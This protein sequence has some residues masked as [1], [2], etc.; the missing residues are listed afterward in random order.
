MEAERILSHINSSQRSDRRLGNDR[1]W[2]NCDWEQSICWHLWVMR[3]HNHC[4]KGQ[5]F[6][7]I[8]FHKWME[9]YFEVLFKLPKIWTT[10]RIR[11]LVVQ[12]YGGPSKYFFLSLP[13]LGVDGKPNGHL[14]ACH[15]QESLKHWQEGEERL[16]SSK[17]PAHFFPSFF[18]WCWYINPIRQGWPGRRGGQGRSKYGPEWASPIYI[19]GFGAF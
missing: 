10:N 2:V 3:V 7:W 8:Y 19:F 16:I 13:R 14:A 5:A 6:E 9:T 12:S 1:Q 4:W 15:L 11:P 17:P 18:C